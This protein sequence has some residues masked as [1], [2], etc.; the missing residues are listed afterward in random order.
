MVGLLIR[1]GAADPVDRW[2]AGRRPG[3]TLNDSGRA[4]V[5]ALVRALTWAPLAAVY[6]SPLERAV[7]TA[8][9]LAR[10]H[11]LDARV[12]PALT[13]IDFGS[14]TGRALDD[15]VHDPEWVRFNG[16]REH[17][18]PPGGE[19]LTEVQRRIMDELMTLARAHQGETVAIVTHAEPIRCALASLAGRTLDEAV[20]IAIEPGH[21]SAIGITARIRRVLG[22]NE[23]A[24][25]HL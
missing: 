23:P 4:Q 18:C 19:A 24:E 5:A 8:Q 13:D 20:A 16:D 2:L 21:V 11:N 3:V 14:W 9:P 1:H 7:E 10:D 22:I 15:L 17:A 12:R 25:V 6:T